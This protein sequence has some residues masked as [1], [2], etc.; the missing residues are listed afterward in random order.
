MLSQ[1]D[2]ERYAQDGYVIPSAFRLPEHEC[3]Q[4]RTGLDAV[5]RDNPQVPPDRLVNAHLVAKPP[6][7][8]KGFTGFHAL[9]RDARIL[10]MVEQVLGP[11]LILWLTHMFCKPAGSGREVPWHQDGQYWSI[12][13]HATCTVWVALD[14]VDRDNGAMRVISG[15]H[16]LGGFRH[17]HDPS[18]RLTLNQVIEPGQFDE[19]EARYIELEPG[20]VSLHDVDI[21]HG[22]APN[23]SGRRRAGLALRYMP[24][25]AWFR[26][27]LEMPNSKLDWA[28]LPIEL[29]RGV[30][31]H[32]ENDLTVGHGAFDVADAR[33]SH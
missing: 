20:Q 15:S 5:L 18:P 25:S 26:R 17:A 32:P 6:Y 19:R 21:L 14:R 24:A 27:D 33:S 23:S 31:R 29:V 2:R 11:D 10:D 22:S 3:A 16:K 28:V 1:Q 7:G 13:P 12:R 9:A 8:L 30:N 4:L